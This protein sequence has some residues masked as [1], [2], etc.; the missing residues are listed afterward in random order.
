MLLEPHEDDMIYSAEDMVPL[1]DFTDAIWDGTPVSMYYLH[2][3]EPV[4][5]INATPGEKLRVFNRVGYDL[6][7][8]TYEAIRTQL[9]ED[10]IDKDHEM[11]EWSQVIATVYSPGNKRRQVAGTHG[12]SAMRP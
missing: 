3:G 6:F 12:A 4:A 10:G 2:P 8:R 1:L 7:I 11:P 9:L 5:T